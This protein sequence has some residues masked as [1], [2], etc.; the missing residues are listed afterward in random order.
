MPFCNVTL[1]TKRWNFFLLP[2]NLDRFYD[3]LWPIEC[4]A[5]DT[6]WLLSLGLK[7][8]CSC[9]FCPLRSQ[10]PCTEVQATLLESH[11]ERKWAWTTRGPTEE[12]RGTHADSQHQPADSLDL[13]ILSASA[14]PTGAEMSC[15]HH[16]CPN[17]WRTKLWAMRWISI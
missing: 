14:D 9:C 4:G 7:R 16:P 3:F 15:S 17:S 10:L 13:S 11:M 1:P 2:L 8:P 12:N 5:S 6:V